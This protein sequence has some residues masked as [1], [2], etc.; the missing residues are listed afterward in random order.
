M[1]LQIVIFIDQGNAEDKNA[2]INVYTK[3]YPI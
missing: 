1:G 3:F 2:H